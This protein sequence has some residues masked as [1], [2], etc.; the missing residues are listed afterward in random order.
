VGAFADA[1][2]ARETRQKVEKLGLKTYTQV[3]QTASGSRIRVRIGPFATRADADAAHA[4]AA[5]AGLTAVVL[6]L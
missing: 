4:K 3:A 1:D 2:A 6:T 5:A